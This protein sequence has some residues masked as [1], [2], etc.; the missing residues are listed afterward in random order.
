MAIK[1]ILTKNADN[2]IKKVF[3]GLLVGVFLFNNVFAWALEEKLFSATTENM[4]LSSGQVKHSL[5]PKLRLT[6]KQFKE[7]FEKGCLLLAHEAINA[8]I[9]QKIEEVDGFKNLRQRED[10]I[11]G[12]IDILVVAIPGLLANRGQF[13]HVGLGKYNS[14]PVIYIDESFYYDAGKLEEAKNRIIGHDTNEILNWLGLATELGMPL[15]SLR[16]RWIYGNPKA[17]K[18]ASAF[19][20]E[21]NRFH[22]VNPLYAEYTYMLDWDEIYRAYRTYGL[23]K[24]DE[25]DVNIAAHKDKPKK[26]DGKKKKKR[27]P[28]SQKVV[29]LSKKQ[30][31][32]AIGQYHYFRFS[33]KFREADL[34]TRII[35]ADT[36]LED[37]NLKGT[38][39]NADRLSFHLD[40]SLKENPLLD[41]LRK[42][43]PFLVD[44]IRAGKIKSTRDVY[45]VIRACNLGGYGLGGRHIIAIILGFGFHTREVNLADWLKSPGIMFP[46]KP[47][48]IIWRDL[49]RALWIG[50]TGG[51]FLNCENYY[52][53]S[54]VQI[55]VLHRG[56]SLK[57]SPGYLCHGRDGLDE[58]ILKGRLEGRIRL[59]RVGHQ[60]ATDDFYSPE[61]ENQAIFIIKTELFEKLRQKR[62]ADLMLFGGVISMADPYPTIYIPVELDDIAEIWVSE[63]TY[64]R[65]QR[66]LTSQDL[67]EKELAMKPVLE[68]L[69]SEDKIREIPGLK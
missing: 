6:Q 66:I 9:K 1:K 32:R 56:R 26:A 28:K 49:Y 10:T 31:N 60:Y 52:D 59:C 67:S 23:D 13:A 50:V 18:K 17:K 48:E 40:T 46:N 24:E 14:K 55:K 15:S 35:L 69:M 21:S 65:Y 45:G 34:L 41:E 12:K 61:S 33:D 16:E 68:R 64:I 29:T 30:Y 37:L 42:R 20:N 3:A 57:F 7:D 4:S 54:G 19:H 39:N 43:I 36:A 25:I 38:L 44:Q 51:E 8:Y 2:I 27:I 62:K 53:S 47:E 5:S 63:E 11:E 22:N 58:V